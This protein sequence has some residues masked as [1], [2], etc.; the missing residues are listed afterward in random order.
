VTDQRSEE[1]LSERSPK[2]ERQWEEILAAV[3]RLA[4]HDFAH[5]LPARAGGDISDYI[6]LG[7]NMLAQVLEE[8]TVSRVYLDS[9][10]DT[11]IDPLFVVDESGVVHANAASARELGV[12]ARSLR[13]RPLETLMRLGEHGTVPL[14]HAQLRACCS[15]GAARDLK[16]RLLCDDGRQLVASVNA[17]ELRGDSGASGRMVLVARDMTEVLGLIEAAREGVRA[18]SEFVAMVS[19]ELRTPMQG[20][21]GTASLMI[22]Q[23]GLSATQ[24]EQLEI[25]QRS[26]EMLVSLVDDVLDLSKLDARRVELAARDFSLHALVRDLVKLLEG[27]A[28]RAGLR[29]LATLGATAPDLVVGDPDRLRQVLLNLCGNAIKFTEHGW[30]ELRVGLL[31]LVEQKAGLRIEVVDTGIGIPR[32]V[33]SA[34]FEPFMRDTSARRFDG[35]GLGLSISRHIVQLMGSELLCESEPGHGSR[36]WFDLTLPLAAATAG[37][38]PPERERASDLAGQG[39]SV[40]VVEDNP[41]LRSLLGSM[42]ATLGVQG[43][44]VANGSDAV[45]A[46]ARARFDLVLMDWD[47]PEMNG[48]DAARAIRD[49]R[50]SQR[51]LPI[52]C[53]TG[54]A[55]REHDSAWAAAGM[56]GLL[57]KPFRITDLKA[58]LS[59][60]MPAPSVDVGG[61]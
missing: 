55:L 13:G 20:V 40:L 57:A 59:R 35:T 7:I 18:R 36:F 24:C 58:V 47:L 22:E 53:M 42:L 52:I 49:T 10:L 2:R 31:E 5:R 60:W 26:S 25:I 1:T 44:I 9:I 15:E 33:Q 28:L 45:Q 43:E 56:D 30:V 6:A 34:I 48:A 17:S 23:G 61:R 32:A 51:H 41:I 19:H 11:M 38:A 54:Y 50:R 8:T 39:G 16:V 29:L 37:A 12:A 21:I 27:R 4:A 46:A 14:S 3:Y